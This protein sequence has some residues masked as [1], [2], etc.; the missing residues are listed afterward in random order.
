MF[1]KIFL[2]QVWWLMSVILP[3]LEEKIGRIRVRDPDKKFMRPPSQQKQAGYGSTPVT[4]T[5]Q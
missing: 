4:P 3:T 5:T 1:K 2:G